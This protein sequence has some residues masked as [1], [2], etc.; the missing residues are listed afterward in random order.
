M[1]NNGKHHFVIRN[2]YIHGGLDVRHNDDL[3]RKV[4]L[5]GHYLVFVFGWAHCG[6]T[7]G[8]FILAQTVCEFR[9]IFFV[10]LE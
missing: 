10:S 3:D 8:E 6:S 2:A 4:S 5:V 9:A 7:G 1:L